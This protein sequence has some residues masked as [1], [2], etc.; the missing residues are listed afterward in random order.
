MVDFLKG[1]TKDLKKAGFDVG[2]SEPPR[3]WF[4][5][6]NYVVNKTLGGSYYKGIPQGRV[7][8]LLGGSG[9]G[10]SFMI[11]NAIREVQQA[12]AICVILDSEHS[13]DDDFVK[14][15]GVDPDAEN[16]I[17]IDIDTFSQC[18]KVVSKFTTDYEKQ[19]GRAHDAPKIV[20]FIDSLGMMITDTEHD[21]Y[22]K[23]ISKGD[24]GQRSKQTKQMLREFVQAIKHLNVSIVV[25]SDVYKNQDPLNGEGLY[26]V[27]D[28]LKYSLS[29][30]ALLSKLKLKDK[31]DPKNVLGIRMKVEGH[32]T[33]FTRPYQ[34]VTIEVPYETG[35]DPY[36]GLVDVAKNIEILTQR[37]A[38]YYLDG[39]EKGWM[40]KDGWDQYKEKI[41]ELCEAKC[42]EFLD[43][44]IL[45]EDVDM[46]GDKSSKSKRVKKH[47]QTND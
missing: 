14:S 6:G 25:T 47:I 13:L 41:L 39:Q 8:G 20:I 40:M 9:S 36:N 42:E 28:A 38:Y 10:K 2:A 35:M 37:G 19:Y 46:S 12:G 34:T 17:Y 44:G 3:Y 33:R 26:I 16:Y 23:G 1:I 11:C 18:K 15:I 5:T 21:H 43:A 7:L 30:I 45:D 32:K 31:N 24:Q 4:S 27:N 29:H 22:I